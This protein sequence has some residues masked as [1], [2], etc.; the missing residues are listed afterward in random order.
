MRSFRILIVDDEIDR[1]LRRGGLE[2]IKS[3]RT[4]EA[5]WIL[6]ELIFETPTI[7]D[8]PL[9]IY[10][11]RDLYFNEQSVIEVTQTGESWDVNFLWSEDGLDALVLDFGDVDLDDEWKLRKGDPNISGATEEQITE[12]NTRYHGAAF[13]LK[14]RERLAHCQAIM[15]FTQYG[16]ALSPEVI[17]QFIKRP[18]VDYETIPQTLM[19]SPDKAGIS[20]LTDKLKSLYIAFAEGYTQLQNL[21]AIDFAATHDEPVLIVGETGTGKEY[22]ARQIHRRWRQ[23]KKNTDIP[24]EPTIINCAALLE[25]LARAELFGHVR[26]SYTGADDHRIGAVLSACGCNGFR[27]NRKG[28][29]HGELRKQTQTF[30]LLVRAVEE[31]NAATSQ[32]E[33]FKRLRHILELLNHEIVGSEYEKS[34][35][36]Y[37]SVIY[38]KLKQIVEGGDYVSEFESSLVGAN[39]GRLRASESGVEF[40]NKKPSGTLFL[41][42]FGDLPPAVQTLLLRYLQSK[43]IQPLGYPRV[44]EGANVRIIAA[45]SDPRVAKFVGVQLYGGWRSKAEMERPIREDLIFRV[46]GQVVRAERITKSNVEKALRHF[47]IQSGKAK[48]WSEDAYKYLVPK[49]KE[50]L[51]LI[52]K[53]V[54]GG[55]PGAGELPAFGHRREL[56]RIV[57]LANAYVT[58]PAVRGLRDDEDVVTGKVIERV[59]KPS[60]VLS[61]K[62]S[63]PSIEPPVG[64]YIA[65]GTVTEVSAAARSTLVGGD[66]TKDV[67]L[68][69]LLNNLEVLFKAKDLPISSDWKTKR[70]SARAIEFKNLVD[71]LVRRERWDLIRD[72]NEDMGKLLSSERGNTP[73]KYMAVFANKPNTVKAWLTRR[74]PESESAD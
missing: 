66:A 67:A 60:V 30:E 34:A 64:S 52:E 74:L 15:F 68:E 32:D 24:K 14:N 20:L 72:I 57:K 16:G 45:T 17:H 12:L 23:G 8:V 73:S 50:Q 3:A 26:G 2:A 33:Q 4:N 65:T 22:I 31:Y 44:I 37:L 1:S 47:V 35:F 13:Y 29:N 18:F 40:I 71:E 58:N 11:A 28:F 59:W 36:K 55:Q 70:P 7:K 46:K 38:S 19:Y 51:E 9:V 10:L 48:K 43:Q 6:K 61:Y 21:A 5:L 63:P 56:D 69:E 41:D 53:A 25:E 54:K 27:S 42:E 49:L 39:P 62:A